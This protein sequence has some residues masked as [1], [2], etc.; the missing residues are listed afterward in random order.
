MNFLFDTI[1]KI[2]EKDGYINATA[3]CKAG[4]KKFNDWYRLESSKSY[5][6]FVEEYTQIPKDKLAEINKGKYGGSW[7][8]PI[9]ATNIAQWIS[10]E[11]AFKVSIWIE[12]WKQNNINKKIYV[13]ELSR[14]IPDKNIL[15]EK[16]IQLRLQI[17]LGGEINVE[18]ENGYIDLLT[19]CEIIEIKDGKNWKHAVGQ[20]L[21]Y[22]FGYPNHKKRIH[23]FN[24]NQNDQVEKS[25]NQYN[26]AVTYEDSNLE[27][28]NEQI[29]TDFE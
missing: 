10:S 24:F 17:E 6:C 20:V 13:K 11:F 8:H 29:K 28:Y 14:I 15:K 26:I 25:C 12:E 4:G 5:L 2:R 1:I 23:L 21:M 27:E 19:S 18:T 22:S 3:L 16:E 9:I 7:I